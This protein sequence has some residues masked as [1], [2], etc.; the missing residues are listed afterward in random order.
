MQADATWN[1]I[2]MSQGDLARMFSSCH[3]VWEPDA[4][5]LL[6]CNEYT[7]TSVLLVLR[8]RTKAPQDL[9]TTNDPTYLRHFQDIYKSYPII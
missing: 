8:V 1:T 2:I 7:S 9:P 6:V 4:V 3:H 5:D